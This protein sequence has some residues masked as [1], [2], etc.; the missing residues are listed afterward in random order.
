M[1]VFDI[2]ADVGIF[3]L[4]AAKRVG[5][6]T[7][8]AFEPNPARASIIERHVRLNHWQARARV[9]P[10]AVSDRDGTIR[11]YTT[12]WVMAGSLSRE[13]AE[14]PGE[15]QRGRAVELEVDS[16]SLDRFCDEMRCVPDVLKIDVE[17]AE[18][19]V[20]RGGR[21]L[22]LTVRPLIFCEVH[23][24]QLVNC[25][26]SLVELEALLFDVGYELE[27]LDCPDGAGIFHARL[28][29][30]TVAAR[31]AAPAAPDTAVL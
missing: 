8:F 11:F 19:L 10:S 14:I 25:G 22:L 27:R 4:G 12:D 31:A 17:G 16:V 18:L 3:T 15:N 7:V 30:R 29:P 28:A 9:I 21:N 20:L 23:P 24:L 26:S 5:D 1:C 6:G 2:G 13:N